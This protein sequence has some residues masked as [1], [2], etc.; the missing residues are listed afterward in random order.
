MKINIFGPRFG[1]TKS[2]NDAVAPVMRVGAL[3]GL[4]LNRRAKS[5]LHRSESHSPFRKKFPRKEDTKE[6]AVMKLGGVCL[7]DSLLILGGKVICEG[8]K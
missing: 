4:S 7:L 6:F 1:I 3:V 8:G 5:G 2:F